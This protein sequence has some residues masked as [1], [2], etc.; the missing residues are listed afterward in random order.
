[1]LRHA[2]VFGAPCNRTPLRAEHSMALCDDVTQI[3]F[4]YQIFDTY[5]PQLQYLKC[6]YQHCVFCIEAALVQK[7]RSE[8]KVLLL[9]RSHLQQLKATT[10]RRVGYENIHYE[11]N[12]SN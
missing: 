1:M 6:I 11:L 5:Q 10:V 8:A 7:K 3:I 2:V 9:D 4:K 12:F